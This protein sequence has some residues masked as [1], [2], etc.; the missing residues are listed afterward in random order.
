MH[1]RVI[2][3]ETLHIESMVLVKA[4]ISCRILHFLLELSLLPKLYN[5]ICL[6]I[7]SFDIKVMFY[8]KMYSMT[9]S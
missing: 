7:K 4:C 9:T 8:V 3:V 2:N 5:P 6:R 1:R